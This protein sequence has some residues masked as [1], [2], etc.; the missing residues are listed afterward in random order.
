MVGK[1]AGYRGETGSTGG[2]TT[3]QTWIAGLSSLL[4]PS[5]TSTTIHTAVEQLDYTGQLQLTPSRAQ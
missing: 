5:I 2:M 4:Q 3:P 1:V